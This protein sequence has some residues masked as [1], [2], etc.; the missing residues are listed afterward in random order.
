MITT[1]PDISKHGDVLEKEYNELLLGKLLAYVEIWK[2]YIGNDGTGRLIEMPN[3]DD[4]E[5]KNRE[6]FSQYH[7]SAFE[8]LVGMKLVV[9]SVDEIESIEDYIR[10]NNEF[11]A[12]QA[13][14]GRI[15]DVIAKMGYHFGFNDLNKKLKDYYQQRNVIL[16]GCKIPFI[17]IEM[18]LAIPP[19]MGSE[20]QP[21]KWHL[22]KSWN[23]VRD[24]DYAI[25]SEY[26][27]ETFESITVLLNNAL[28][29]LLPRV[30]E[31]VLSKGFVLEI[32]VKDDAEHGFVISGANITDNHVFISYN[33]SASASFF[34]TND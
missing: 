18:L 34:N 4:Q 12:F 1:Q 10:A 20:E 27:E 30:K 6:M 22:K 13:H 8:S 19:I 31:F 32:P 15:H 28:N 24:E 2:H 3:L 16:H 17:F 33:T 5:T 14:A 25:L 26:L 9:D 7:Y 11:L 21:E 23:E 29:R